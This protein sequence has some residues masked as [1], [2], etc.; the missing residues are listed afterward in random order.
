MSPDVHTQ[1]LWQKR[2]VVNITSVI[3]HVTGLDLVRIVT[4][5]L[6]AF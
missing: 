6:G 4:D 3:M 5:N 1:I 2:N